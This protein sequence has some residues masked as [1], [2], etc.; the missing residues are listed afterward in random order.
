M[1]NQTALMRVNEAPLVQ[2]G[3]AA[4]CAAARG[5]FDEYRTRR[6]ANTLR[7]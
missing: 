7:V 4:D 2:A 3:Q 6:A 1:D 5:L